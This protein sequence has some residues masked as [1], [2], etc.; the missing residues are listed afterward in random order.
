M[1]VRVATE[2]HRHA[3]HADI[4]RETIDGEA[5]YLQRNDNLPSHEAGWWVAY[6]ARLEEVAESFR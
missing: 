2:T 3:G 5:G 4:L 6:R 1:M